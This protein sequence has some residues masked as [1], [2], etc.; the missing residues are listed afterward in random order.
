MPK[1]C[2]VANQRIGI[3]AL[4]CDT[5]W[6]IW[7]KSKP[8]AFL[9]YLHLLMRQCDMGKVWLHCSFSMTCALSTT[10]S[11][12]A[13]S[14]GL[15]L[16]LSLA[17][18]LPRVANPP[19]FTP[20][21]P[22]HILIHIVPV[23]FAGRAPGM[24]VVHCDVKSGNVII[25]RGGSAKLADLGIAR[26]VRDSLPRTAAALAAASAGPGA[27]GGGGGGSGALG[28][29]AWMAPENSDEECR[30]YGGPA[31]DVYSLVGQPRC[32]VPVSPARLSF[33]GWHVMAN[34]LSRRLTPARPATRGGRA[35]FCG[36]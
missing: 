1:S 11:M 14:T 6:P 30:D 16:Q 34:C 18:R 23:I 20:H 35:W 13:L 5:S 17:S 2:E 3:L 21:T 33:L 27:L 4:T 29:V 32:T 8:C 12:L 10:L 7:H 28:S 24:Q 25:A 26:R 15:I 36:R 31:S 19:R 22:P 9:A